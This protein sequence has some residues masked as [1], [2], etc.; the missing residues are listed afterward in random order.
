MKNTFKIVFPHSSLSCKSNFTFF[1]CEYVLQIP[2]VG[3]G[4]VDTFFL[5][6]TFCS[7]KALMVTL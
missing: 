2:L 3:N 1:I 5:N 6:Y 4:V 7:S